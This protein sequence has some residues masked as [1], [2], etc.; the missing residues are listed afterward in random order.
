MFPGEKLPV[1]GETVRIMW[2]VFS[3]SA[4]QKIYVS[5]GEDSGE[6]VLGE[7]IPADK[8]SFIAVN[9]PVKEDMTGP[10][11]ATVWSDTP[12]ICSTSFADAK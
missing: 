9:I 8:E 4:V 7:N 5:L 11:Y 6:Y 2:P 1:A 3:E 10:V 12:T